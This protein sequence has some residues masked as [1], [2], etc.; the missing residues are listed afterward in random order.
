MLKSIFQIKRAEINFLFESLLINSKT[1]KFLLAFLVFMFFMFFIFFMFFFPESCIEIFNMINISIFDRKIN[2]IFLFLLISLLGKNKKLLS[3]YR[4]DFFIF[5]KNIYIYV[6]FYI[7]EKII[8]FLLLFIVFYFLIESYFFSFISFYNLLFLIFMFLLILVLNIF[9][10]MLALKIT[11]KSS[12]NVKNLFYILLYA[13]FLW[14]CLTDYSYFSKVSDYILIN[15]P[16]VLLLTNLFIYS[17]VIY[18]NSSYKQLFF[19]FKYLKVPFKN[20]ILN[21]FLFKKTFNIYFSLILLNIF[22]LILIN[23]SFLAVFYYFIISFLAY[24]IILF[25]IYKITIY[26]CY[27]SKKSYVMYFLCLEILLCFTV[28]NIFIFR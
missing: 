19:M 25:I 28:F 27:K 3:L 26:E 7:K 13:V 15:V 11:I 18:L 6:Y 20:V 16:L 14:L 4:D 17:E 2:I 21:T 9:Y 23:E 10:L 5:Y 24:I 22:G 12:Y 8:S 1:N